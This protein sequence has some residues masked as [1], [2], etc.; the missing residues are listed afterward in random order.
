M[1]F[2]SFRD[3]FPPPCVGQH[4][5]FDST[6]RA[7]HALARTICLS[8]GPD[9]HACPF[10]I[11][12]DQRRREMPSDPHSGPEGTWAGLLVG[13]KGRPGRKRKAA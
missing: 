13:V 7:D 5:L 9:G 3:E 1:T 2:L 4:H 12:C 10:I 8:G 6:Y 11:A